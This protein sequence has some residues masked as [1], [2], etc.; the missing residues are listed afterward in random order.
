[1]KKN[2][3]C[4][5]KGKYIQ[6]HDTI[7]SKSSICKSYGAWWDST[8]K[9]WLWKPTEKHPTFN[10][11]DFTNEYTNGTY[12]VGTNAE[13][14][15]FRKQIDK[16]QKQIV[17]EKEKWRQGKVP[18]DEKS[19]ED[20]QV[21]KRNKILCPDRQNDV[22][23]FLYGAMPCYCKTCRVNKVFLHTDIDC[24][25]HHSIGYIIGKKEAV[26]MIIEKNLDPTQYEYYTD[27]INDLADNRAVTLYT[28]FKK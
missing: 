9:I 1:M 23:V 16:L 2:V 28:F 27:P 13:Y 10:I 21:Q 11:E 22:F 3:K 5:K 18:I 15:A 14:W 7:A 26:Q 25:R 4:I 12:N 20:E 17:I 24:K 8:Q 6:I 19:S